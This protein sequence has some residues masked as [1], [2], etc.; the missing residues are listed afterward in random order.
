MVRT[1]HFQKYDGITISQ[2]ELRVDQTHNV[3]AIYIYIYICVYVYI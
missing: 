1:L 3:R 2:L